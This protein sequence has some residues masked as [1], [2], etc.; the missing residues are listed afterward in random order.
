LANWDLHANLDSRGAHLF[1]EF[2]REANIVAGP[3]DWPR[4]LPASLNY[5]VPFQLERPLETPYGLNT[6]DNP[7]ALIALGMA[8]KKLQAAAID[9][10]AR[11]GDIQGVT[12]NDEFIPSLHGGPEIEGVFNKMEFDFAG[13]DGYPDVTG[14]SGSWIM[15]T[16]LSEDGPRAKGILSYSISGNPESPHYSDMTRRLSNKQFLD[17]PYTQEEVRAAALEEKHVTEGVSDCGS[18]GWRKYE[19]PAFDSQQQCVRYY[20]NIAAERLT[21]FVT[22]PWKQRLLPLAGTNNARDMGGYTTADGR[23]VRWGQLFRSD[24]LANLN[25]TDLA[26]LGN[27][28]LSAVTDFRG[29]TER[30]AAPDRL[31]QQTPPIAYRTVAINDPA[32]DVAELGRKVYAGL[33]SEAEL[34]ALTDRQGYVNEPAVS[35]MWGQWLARLA[36]PDNL[37]HL[38]HCTAGK[39]RTG[40]AAAIVL[41][42]LGVPRDQVMEDFLLSNEYR[43]AG[44]EANIEKIQAHSE[45]EVDAEVLR[46]VLGVSPRSLDDAIS[47]MEEKYGSIDGFIEH[48][49]GIDAATRAKLQELLLE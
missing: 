7:D 19:S 12:R 2:M 28:Q 30:A 36:D 27:L 39:D 43:R 4:I 38:F 42:T 29:D 21:H 37:P 46:Q 17:L 1:R 35:R 18:E 32:V 13:A 49:L 20:E 34:L 15:A 24:S 22:R 31:P 25:D 26:Y 6:D 47:A 11:L 10:D 5:R 48:G 8:I 3:T 44:I 23:A 41:L 33:L 14:S 16:E 45:H 40:F 9:L